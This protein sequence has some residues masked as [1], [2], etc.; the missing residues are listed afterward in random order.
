[1]NLFFN[2]STWTHF[3]QTV[4]KDCFNMRVTLL[5]YSVI[6]GCVCAWGRGGGGS[7]PDQQAPVG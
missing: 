2:L 6:F 3:V 4:F 5:I 7:S 1:M